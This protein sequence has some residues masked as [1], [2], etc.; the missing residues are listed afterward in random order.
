GLIDVSIFSSYSAGGLV[1]YWNGTGSTSTPVT[2]CYATG[3]VSAAYYYAGGLIGKADYCSASNCFAAVTV[4]GGSVTSAGGLL[5]Q[6][7]PSNTSVTSCY[8]TGNVTASG[9]NAC[10]GGLIGIQT[11]T[12][13]STANCYATG[14]TTVLIYKGGVIGYYD[15]G[16]VTGC[17]YN[18]SAGTEKGIGNGTDYTIAKT[19][20]YMKSTDFVTDLNTGY[21]G[22]WA[23]DTGSTNQGYPV[24]TAFAV[25]SGS[26]TTAPAVTDTAIT[27]SNLTITGVTLSWNKATDDTSAQTALE[28]LVYRS[29]SNNLDTVTNIEA[30]GTAV[31]SYA[32]DIATK[33]ITGLSAGTTYY[34]NVIV[35]D[36]AGNKTCYTTESVTTPVGLELGSAAL[37]GD[38]YYYPNVAVSGSNIKTI[39]IAFSDNVISGDQ[40]VLP[41]A[42]A[43]FTVSSTSNDYTKR[44]NLADGTLT[45]AVQDYLRAVGF[46]VASDSQT[47][48]I[49]VTT[50]NITTDTFYNSDTEH[51]YQFLP[52]GEWGIDW[53]TAYTT[54]KGMTYMG[55]TGY[56]A[57]VTTLSE[58]TFLNSLSGGSTGWLG[59]T[60]LSHGTLNGLYYDSFQTASFVT[61]GWY[62]ACGP[63]IGD[64]FY[65]VTTLTDA[66]PLETVDAE[67]ASLGYYFNWG[68]G[69][70]PNNTAGGENCLTTLVVSGSPGKQGTVFSWND[71][72]YDLTD[73][74]STYSAK[75]YFVEYGNQLTGD[76]GSGSA[77]FAS[78]IGELAF[79]ST[80]A[81]LKA[82]STVKGATV[83]LGTPAGTLGSETAGSVM[84]TSAQAADTSN[85][86]SYITLFDKNDGNATVK[87]VKYASGASTTNFASD[88]AYANEAISNGDFFIVRVT[89]QDGVTINYYRIN[90]IVAA[91]VEL[92]N[93]TWKS[94]S[95]YTCGITMSSPCRIIT[96]SV[97]SGYITVPS[98]GS[99]VLTFL[100]GTNGTTYINSYSAGQQF[101]SVVFSFTDI[102]AAETLLSNIVYSLNGTAQQT[103]TAT[104]S[105]V[106]PE[107]G[108]TF[109]DGHFYRYVATPISWVDA[110]LAAG[111]TAD[112]YFGGRG[113]LAT[114]TSQAENS[115]LL[116]L[117]DTGGT[118]DDHWND[119]WMGGLWQ[120][121]TGTVSSPSITRGT[122]GNEISYS[123]LCDTT[124]TEQKNLLPHYVTLYSTDAI[125]NG[126][127]SYIY[128]HP[129]TVLYYWVDGPEAGQEIAN[130]V[131]DGFSPWHSGEPNTG[132]FVYI[133]LLGPYWDDLSAY[134]GSSFAKLSGYIVEFSGFGEGG[135]TEGIVASDTKIMDIDTTA[136][137]VT[138]K[139][140]TSSNITRTGATLSWNKATDDCSTQADLEYLV[141][142]STSNNLG[143]VTDIE[144]NGTA[145]GSYAADIATKD[146]TVLTAGTTYYFNVIVKDMAGNKTCY[147]TKSVTTLPPIT[148][149][150]TPAEALT[151]E[152]LDANSLTVALSNVTFK[153]ATLDEANFTLNNA[154]AG[155]SVESVEYTDTTHCKVSLAYDDT[156]FDSNVT[157]FSLTIKIAELSDNDGD[158]TSDELTITALV[159]TAPTVTTDSVTTYTATTAVLGGDVTASGGESVTERGIVYSSTDSTPEIGETGVTKNDNGLGT[160]TFSETITGLA[161]GTKYYVRAYAT[162]IEGTSY[163]SVEEFT[164]LVI[165]SAITPAEALTEENLDANSLTV[166]LSNVTFKD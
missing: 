35:K 158:L 20:E 119:A 22:T 11:G 127:T 117:V 53:V 36:E 116:K 45:S 121:N 107:A 38:K 124:F 25:D 50:E 51:Y 165:T 84:L 146:A 1:G 13:S 153:D 103:I 30:N 106:S 152:N 75:G 157:T 100:G 54:A 90:V 135:S 43:G 131:T 33:D 16:S 113:Y 74:A 166:A 61:N 58:D 15:S 52:A 122:D 94:G 104:A 144:A 109:F 55:R 41:T 10:A 149:A 136:P 147:T 27:A 68:R 80:D 108:D 118:G 9:N 137:S 126:T 12:G 115:I 150:I 164:T 28:Y 73:P 65:N 7:G 138:D 123:D 32:A 114:A 151:E 85:T 132:D 6:A 156:D 29:S 99:G 59:G 62:W 81:T 92:T 23:A 49:T 95:T 63:E 140:I 87:A 163:G 145:L 97:N 98:L 105:S 89:A 128:Q 37:T 47:V 101:N 91:T 48:N 78:A 111:S 26:D 159:E 110:A 4:T 77:A 139:T 46:A 8:A 79:L 71:I 14:S 143:T 134:D 129:E 141:Y 155:V 88:T 93:V 125:C 154:P 67:N 133:G 57:T 162:N 130:N 66:S 72:S 5:G 76:D 42:P 142:R 24:L 148:A 112:P 64:L 83:A 86:G 70:E 60:I 31:G 160:D 82:S 19:S 44:I 120:R 102:P 3:S 69:N 56:L 2:N 39:L 161:Q 40:I 21:T 96:I 34:F 18:S 17:Y